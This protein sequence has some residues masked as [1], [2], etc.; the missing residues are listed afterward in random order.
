VTKRLERVTRELEMRAEKLRES[1]ERFRLI[2]DNLREVIWISD[3]AYTTQYY[4]SPAYEM[5]WGRSIEEARSD[6][7]SFL[8]AVVSEDRDRVETAL[9]GYARGE[10]AAEYRIERTDGAIRWISARSYP[11]RDEHGSIFRIAGI[12]E[13]IT[14]QKQVEE[15]REELLER[16]RHAHAETEAALHLRDRVVRIVSHDLKNPLHTIGMAADLLE[17]PLT[18]DQREKQ[19][20]II[21]R[22]V[23]RANRM[24]SD[25]LDVARLQSGREMSIER[26]PLRI[27]PLLTEAVEA[28]RFQAERKHQQL[29]CDAPDGLP[30]VLADHDRLVQALTNLIGNAVKFTPEGGRIHVGTGVDAS[31][32]VRFEVSDTGRG[33]AAGLLPHLFEPFT[34]A[35]DTATLGT[36]LGLSIT[37]GI[38]EAHGGAI[39]VRSEPGRG[40]TFTFTLPA[41]TA[42]PHGQ[43][44]TDPV[45]DILDDSFPASDPPPWWGR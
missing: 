15:E 4:L 23:A 3:P 25:L 1:E 11:V 7:R 22:T 33:I 17:M 31:G 10:Y 40:T 35:R 34:Q 18:G 2:A 5:I 44:Y 9:E 28:F 32:A 19:L 24:V 6:P 36:G 16:E 21:R 41:H 45:D 14:A 13:D 29:T 30:P 39:T 42:S 38:V 27:Q 12:L 37:R 43:V 8:Q 20:D 26:R